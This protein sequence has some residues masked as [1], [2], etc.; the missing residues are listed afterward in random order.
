MFAS[1]PE[2]FRKLIRGHDP[3]EPTDCWKRRQ[4]LQTRGILRKLAMGTSTEVDSEAD[5]E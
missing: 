1:Q 5:V 3:Y 4:G 2:E